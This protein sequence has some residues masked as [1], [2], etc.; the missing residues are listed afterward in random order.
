MKFKAHFKLEFDIKTNS[1]NMPQILKIIGDNITKEFETNIKDY[2]EM[3]VMPT[4]TVIQVP[5]FGKKFED[6]DGNT[7]CS[8]CGDK[9]E[10][11]YCSCYKV[12]DNYE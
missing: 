5:C 6:N 2:T 8:R 9:V 10:G 1:D 7:R 4:M 3:E 11:G 12:G